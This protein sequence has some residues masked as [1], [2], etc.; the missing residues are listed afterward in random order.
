MSF[1][2]LESTWRLTERLRRENDNLDNHYRDAATNPFMESLI[3]PV[4]LGRHVNMR[5]LHGLKRFYAAKATG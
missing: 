1:S 4:N 2:D 5:T 3:I